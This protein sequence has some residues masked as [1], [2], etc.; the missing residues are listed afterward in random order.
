MHTYCEVPRRSQ[1]NLPCKEQPVLK[2]VNPLSLNLQWL[3]RSLSAPQY[4]I[5]YRNM[6]TGSHPPCHVSYLHPVHTWL[7]ACDETWEPVP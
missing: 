6:L 1:Q 4:Q 3:E 2:P 7:R 5:L